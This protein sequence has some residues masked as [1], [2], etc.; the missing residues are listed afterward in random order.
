VSPEKIAPI[1]TIGEVELLIAI[2]AV[3]PV[4]AAVGTISE[5][6][7]LIRVLLIVVGGFF[8]EKDTASFTKDPAGFTKAKVSFTKR[9]PGDP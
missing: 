6:E 3:K 1:G 7:A 5:I 8:W 4:V 2:A 9:K